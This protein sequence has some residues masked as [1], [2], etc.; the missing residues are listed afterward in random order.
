MNKQLT[1]LCYLL[2]WLVTLTAQAQSLNFTRIGLQEG[3]SQNTVLDID[4]DRLGNIW[5]ATQNG[6]N[7]YNGYEFTVYQHDGT[8]TTSIGNN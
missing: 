6:L 5:M 7:K 4:Q 2:G 8:H 3:L 1:I